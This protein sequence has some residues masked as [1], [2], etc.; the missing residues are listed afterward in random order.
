M[1]TAL[2]FFLIIITIIISVFL[3]ALLILY[4]RLSNRID[5]VTGKL[6][7]TDEKFNSINMTFDD[8]DKRINNDINELE[9]RVNQSFQNVYLSIE[10]NKE[11][12]EN[13]CHNYVF[14][15]GT[16][17]VKEPIFIKNIK[18]DIYKD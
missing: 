18:Q 12:I 3:T 15:D 7:Q 9:H 8:I 4:L 11:D 13:H 1:T 6:N 17:Y 16:L 2:I 10:E 14:D 5:E